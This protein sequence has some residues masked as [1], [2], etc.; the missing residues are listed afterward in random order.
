MRSPED[1]QNSINNI[2][3]TVL[4]LENEKW[5]I[6]CEVGIVAADYTQRIIDEC[7]EKM[8]ELNAQRQIG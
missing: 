6:A 1:I 4:L 8:A 5:V 2:T 7:Y 3:K